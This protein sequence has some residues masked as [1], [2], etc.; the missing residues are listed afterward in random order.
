MHLELHG[1]CHDGLAILPFFGIMQTDFVRFVRINLLCGRHC[2]FS[3]SYLNVAGSSV[4]RDAPSAAPLE[5]HSESVYFF[6]LWQHCID[7]FCPHE[8]FH[9]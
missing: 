8:N 3:T 5:N 2:T 1:A 7:K 6:V 4:Q 9:V